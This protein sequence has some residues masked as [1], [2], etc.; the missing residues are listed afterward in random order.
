MAT[1][2]SEQLKPI[3][4][5][6]L[7]ALER[8]VPKDQLANFL[9]A[10]YVPQPKQLEFHAACRMCDRED[11]PDQ[12]GFGGA[13]GPGKSHAVFAQIALDDCQRVPDLKVLYLRRVAKNAREQFEDLRKAV[14]R[15]VSHDYNRSTG[16]ITFPNGSRIVLGHF[17][18][19]RDVDQYL[20]IEYDVIVPEEATTLTGSKY[21]TLRDSNR[22]S[23]P[24]W[25]PRMYPSTNPG[26][27]GHVWF[28]ERFITPA[29][30]GKETDTRFI[31]ATVDDNQFID[32]GYT[33]KLEENTG[34]KLRAYRYGDWDIAAGQYFSTWHHASVV[35]PW[36]KVPAHWTVWAAMDYGFTHPTVVYLLAENDG[37]IY[38]LDEHRQAKW[39]PS[40]HAPAIIAMLE[41][42]GVPLS[43]LAGFVAGADVF[44]KKGDE[45]GKDIAEQ[46]AE[47][48]IKLT[49]AI[50][51]RINGWGEALT[52]LGD[53]V[54]QEPEKRRAP[55]IQI[56]NKCQYLIECIPALQHNPNKPEDVLKWDVDEDGNGGDDPG[57]C[58]RYGVMFKQQKPIGVLKW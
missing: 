39:L 22:T 54:N 55:K 56:S 24:G 3:D 30:L 13:R 53:P 8:G 49:P 42:N 45:A 47:H 7:A 25:R 48:K 11:G 29:R 17:N 14:M 52:L 58:L 46:Y 9:R 27:V 28:K 36:F 34:W 32:S 43:R 57:D 31:F 19:E 41:R 38:V 51:D 44:A 50:M 21:K 40:Q 15:Y 16:L 4:R 2:G 20:G 6:A 37:K 1:R 23:K 33:K 18:N 12:I 35:R 26:N 10:G 5:L